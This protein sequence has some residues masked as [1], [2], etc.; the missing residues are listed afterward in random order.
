MKES[1]QALDR[2]PVATSTAQVA[3][4]G[5]LA[6]PPRERVVDGWSTVEERERFERLVL[7]TNRP[8]L[9]RELLNLSLSVKELRSRIA[10]VHLRFKL[11]QVRSKASPK[12]A[13]NPGFLSKLVQRLDASILYSLTERLDLG[14]SIAE[15]RAA[16]TDA[17]CE[18]YQSY[19]QIVTPRPPGGPAV[20]FEEFVEL[21]SAIQTGVYQVRWCTTCTMHYPVKTRT[22]HRP[23]D[24]DCPFC[25]QASLSQARQPGEES[26]QTAASTGRPGRRQGRGRAAAAGDMVLDALDV[27]AASGGAQQDLQT[28]GRLPHRRSG[29]A[30]TGAPLVE[31]NPR[32]RAH[33]GRSAVQPARIA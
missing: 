20:K 9:I 33:S 13:T 7:L 29:T 32:A 5:Q 4:A 26:A 15:S 12:A 30:G 11:K 18:I 6:A 25:E 27:V 24:N 14:V 28:V 16:Y 23:G 8:S 31:A 17:L 3:E 22:R 19:V 10:T 21:L 2:H 1:K